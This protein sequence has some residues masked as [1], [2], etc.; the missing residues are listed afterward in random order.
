[1]G[2]AAVSR[3]WKLVP[4]L[5]VAGAL[6]GFAVS[7][8]P[9]AT[10]TATSM[11]VVPPDASA[12]LSPSDTP[13]Q[14]AD[15]YIASQVA[16]LESPGVAQK[17]SAIVNEA[18]HRSSLRSSD[19][20]EGLQVSP[21]ALPEGAGL[22]RGGATQSSSGALEAVSLTASEPKAA[23]AGA[24]AVVTAYAQLR[25]D[26]LRAEASGA[27]AALDSSIAQTDARI[28]F[29]TGAIAQLRA[30]SPAA[31]PTTS[32]DLQQLQS[33]QAASSSRRDQ[34]ASRLA[35]IEADE[36]LLVSS[37]I[38][39]VPAR[40]GTVVASSD[41]VSYALVG[42]AAG[43]GAGVLALVAVAVRSYQ[44]RKRCFEDRFGPKLI[45]DAPLLGEVPVLDR[46][47]LASKLPVSADPTSAAAE[48]FRFIAASLK[49]L[50]VSEGPVTF[51]FVSARSRAG[52]TV[53]SANVA[54]ALA[55]TGCRVLAVDADFLRQDLSRT[56]LGGVPP[57]GLVEVMEGRLSLDDA[58]HEV[59]A[60]ESGSLEVLP[61]GL[62]GFLVPGMSRRHL[63]AFMV[64]SKLEHDVVLVD[65]P[66]LL[67]AAYAT[68]LVSALDTVVALAGHHE[69]LK[70][71]PVVVERLGLV[72]T[73]V[74][75]Y[76]YNRA[77]LRDQ[78]SSYYR[79]FRAGGQAAPSAS[80]S[81]PPAPPRPVAA[82]PETPATL[83]SR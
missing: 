70:D 39:S 40:P 64:R 66:P 80:S 65:G 54:L 16:L 78:I 24:N 10:Y 27:I 79:E 14:P 25:A 34:L 77:P 29:L 3:Q 63:G 17:A 55:Q 52:K 1:M 42:L 82:E 20:L 50:A 11:L 68:D 69:A 18:E 75:G 73:D 7:F 60:S 37:Q 45:Y 31:A 15:A 71:H 28:S 67:E 41:H 30:L 5:A 36:P 44:S 51:S 4:V 46:Q 57:A 13:Q 81:A 33:Q 23:V 9:R 53:V 76:V 72:R 43:V 8:L 58:V 32:P 47:Q 35:Q 59:A 61:G 38:S 21:A 49:V 2:G 56:L 74:C 22:S 6:V 48:S 26:G 19:V 12:S 83:S 62:E